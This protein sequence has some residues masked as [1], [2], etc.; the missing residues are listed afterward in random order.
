[1]GAIMR[2]SST[3]VE[4]SRGV[5]TEDKVAVGAWLGTSTAVGAWSAWTAWD[6]Y[7]AMNGAYY[8]TMT[9][10]A[11][12]TFMAFLYSAGPLFV[13]IPAFVLA[14]LAALGGTADEGTDGEPGP[15]LGVGKRLVY[16]GLAAGTA[17]G[18]W[19]ALLPLLMTCAAAT[20]LMAVR[21]PKK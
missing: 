18:Y 3:D 8:G 13:A 14:A 10:A 7:W 5:A 4:V 1:M 15:E 11:K 2:R 6:A 16:G 19:Y 17:V 9:A 21:R 20:G 12:A